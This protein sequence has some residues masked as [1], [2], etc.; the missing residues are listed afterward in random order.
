MESCTQK[1]F[2]KLKLRRSLYFDIVYGLIP[3][4]MSKIIK[5]KS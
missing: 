5:M 3:I 4:N 1:N 2:I